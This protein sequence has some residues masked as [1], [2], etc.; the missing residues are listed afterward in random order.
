[1]LTPRVPA[2]LLGVAALAVVLAA[3]GASQTPD[4]RPSATASTRSSPSPA[5]DPAVLLVSVDGLNPDAVRELGDRLPAF[6]RLMREGA[7]TLNARSSYELT[8]TLPN[9]TGMLT[10]RRVSG[11]E[12]TSVTFNDDSGGTLAAT[13]GSY[14]PGVFDVAHDHGLTTALFAEKPKFEYLLR[15]WDD[16]NG[17]ADRTGADD[18]SDKV[19]DSAIDGVDTLADDVRIAL[20]DGD[21][22][23]FWHMAAPDHEGHAHG[24]LG[25][26]YLKAV[27]STD[28]HLGELLAWLDDHPAVRDRLTVILTADHG[29]PRGQKAHS[30]ATLAANYT[31][32]FIVWGRG[33]AEHTDLYHL[34]PERRD[35]GAGRP[36]YTGSQPIRNLDAAD[37]ALSLLGLPADLGLDDSPLSVR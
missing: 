20:D 7:S 28:A 36:G 16:R 11:P 14:V 18:G 25:P 31:I 27:E 29:G 35:P 13:H 17:A 37:L 19:D 8:I 24:W 3:C 5:P 26:Q 2:R 34:N 32:P 1:M 21:D 23:V 12:G 10:G 15:S 30:D 6:T 33:V 22:L 4:P 9:H